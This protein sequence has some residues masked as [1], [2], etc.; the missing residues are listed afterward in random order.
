M[1]G[2]GVWEEGVKVSTRMKKEVLFISLACN[3]G[4]L[5]KLFLN[6]RSS[7]KTECYWKHGLPNAETSFRFHKSDIYNSPKC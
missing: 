6:S 2:M 5:K 3:N 7:G 4:I 1:E